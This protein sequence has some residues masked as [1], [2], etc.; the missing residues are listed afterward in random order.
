MFADSQAYPEY[1]SEFSA[2][3]EACK[4]IVTKEPDMAAKNVHASLGFRWDS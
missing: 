4:K 1:V 3:T 2:G